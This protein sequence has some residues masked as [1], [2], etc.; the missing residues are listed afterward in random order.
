MLSDLLLHHLPIGLERGAVGRMLGRN[1]GEN[2]FNS[3]Y[4]VVWD[5]GVSAMPNNELEKLDWLYISFDEHDR[6][7]RVSV[8]T[9]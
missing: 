2:L 9:W 5:L 1:S 3:D 8:T 4:I 6:L 7:T